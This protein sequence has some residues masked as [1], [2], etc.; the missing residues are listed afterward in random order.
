[1]KYIHTLALGLTLASAVILSPQLAPETSALDTG[2]Y[3]QSSR[4][5]TGKWARVAV[6]QSGMQLITTQQLRALG[7]TDLSRV[8]V[9]GYGGREIPL[10]LNS[11]Y[12]DDL[13]EQPSV[14]TSKG[15]V[16][17]G[18]DNVTWKAGQSGNNMYYEDTTL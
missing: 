14:Q 1:M 12:V 9:H 10:E 11:S 18:V 6:S 5:A 4:L 7:F 15:I 13:P 17:F 8:R 3:R 2:L 16:F